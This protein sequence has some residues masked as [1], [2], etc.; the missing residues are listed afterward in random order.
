MEI[1]LLLAKKY[2]EILNE[3]SLPYELD[4]FQIPLT[5]NLLNVKSNL[6]I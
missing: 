1:M 6:S 2:A 5:K 3:M 4:D